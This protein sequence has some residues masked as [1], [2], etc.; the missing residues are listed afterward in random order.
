[1]RTGFQR[2][3]RED[4]APTRS[5]CHTLRSASSMS[6]TGTKGHRTHRACHSRTCAPDLSRFK[7]P[8]EYVFLRSR[9]RQIRCNFWMSSNISKA[10]GTSVSRVANLCHW[11]ARR[12]QRVWHN[13]DSMACECACNL[14]QPSKPLLALAMSPAPALKLICHRDWRSGGALALCRCSLPPATDAALSTLTSVPFAS[15]L[16]H[17]L[18][19]SLAAALCSLQE[20]ASVWSTCNAASSIDC[21]G[22]RTHACNSLAQAI[23]V[24][25]TA[26][27][28]CRCIKQLEVCYLHKLRQLV[29]AAGGGDSGRDRHRRKRFR[30]Q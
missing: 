19:P 20:G 2:V 17:R 7:A 3:S 30:D 25:R 1:M 18:Y 26:A 29:E 23:S 6:S 12:V 16:R 5:I 11:T 10:G 24:S 8:F 27:V 9:Q 14:D 4:S 28:K 15:T 22:T 13:Q 21:L